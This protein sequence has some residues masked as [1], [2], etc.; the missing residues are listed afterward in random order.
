MRLTIF[1]IVNKRSTF[2]HDLWSEASYFISVI[3]TH[4][5][6]SNVWSKWQLD[7]HLVINAQRH[8]HDLLVQTLVMICD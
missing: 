6:A 7:Y 2:V 3:P 1:S 8:P 5:F 4:M